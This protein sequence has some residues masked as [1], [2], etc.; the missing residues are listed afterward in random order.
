METFSNNHWDSVW[1]ISKYLSE[2]TATDPGARGY[3]LMDEFAR[4]G[5]KV[6][7]L[8]SDAGHHFFGSEGLGEQRYAETMNVNGM[9]LIR[10]RTLKY[11]RQRSIRRVLS[12]IDFELRL[13]AMPKANFPKPDVIIASSLSLLTIIS[14]LLLRMRYRCKLV[15][16]VRD[17][18]PLTLVEEGGF[19]KWNP[20]IMVLAC[21]ERLGYRYSDAVVGTMPNL[22]EHVGSVVSVAPPVRCIP[23]GYREI[24][25]DKAETKANPHRSSFSVPSGKFV[26]GYAGSMGVSNA[27]D[28]LLLCAEGLVEHDKIHIALLGEGDLREYYKSRFGHLSNVSFLE[29]VSRREV[30]AFLDRCDLLYFA[31]QA[32]TVWRFGQSLNKIIDYMLAGKP[33]LGSFTGH[34]TMI[35]EA[36]CGTVVPAG[37]VSALRGELLRFEGLG[38]AACARLGYRARQW[39]IANRNYQVLGSEYL[40]LLKELQ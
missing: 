7:I 11:T 19:S 18:W 8:S 31:T 22:V 14:G 29:P 5:L 25:N 1:Y 35:N 37:D 2:P 32:S 3:H 6:T 24:S 12:W 13:L 17:I 38:S 9:R 21:I 15:F 34:L 39:V 10:V 27:L 4:R 33:I 23:I 20:L 28:T 26:V 40:S 16:E 30:S 36:D